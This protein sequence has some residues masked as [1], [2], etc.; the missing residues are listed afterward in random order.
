MTNK[1]SKTG[2][3]YRTARIPKGGGRF[4]EIIIPGEE[5]RKDLRLFFLEIR[6]QMIAR[7]NA[8]VVHGFMP[9]RSSVTNA[10]YHAGYR[11]TLSMDLVSFFDAVTR[12][13][14]QG[15]I[16]D[17]VLDRVLIDNV[18]KQGLSTS[19]M[20]ANLAAVEMDKMLLEMGVRYT[21]YADDLT[22]S[23]DSAETILELKET[24]PAI[25]SRCGFEV[26][27]KK[28]RTQGWRAGRRIITGLAVDHLVQET[29]KNKRKR[30]AAEHQGHEGGAGGLMHWWK[31]PR[32]YCP[33]CNQK[34]PW[35]RVLTQL[36]Q[37]VTFAHYV[38]QP[39][40]R[41]NARDYDSLL[42]VHGGIVDYTAVYDAILADVFVHKMTR[43]R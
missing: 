4:R 40:S 18:A 30:R 24:V 21:R 11:Y 29:R 41:R 43:E 36:V 19:P 34:L 26:N 15:I 16:R 27:Q 8:R 14:L 9:G 39:R 37:H 31:S 10:S 6:D 3:R 13:H 38:P 33:V 42:E 35:V 17:F 5:M 20:L 7:C 2:A 1:M 23:G 12:E 25:V 28:T 32:I 22:F